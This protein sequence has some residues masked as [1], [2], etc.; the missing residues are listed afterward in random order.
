MSS[1][2]PQIA[3]FGLNGQL[4]QEFIKAFTSDRYKGH[5]QLPIRA[6]TR[7]P[8]KYA[9]TEDVE[10]VKADLNDAES[11]KAA[12]TGVNVVLDVTGHSVSSKP[13]IDAAVA[14]GVSLFFNS[15]FGSDISVPNMKWF[16]EAYALKLEEADYA[17]QH[18]QLKTVSVRNDVFADFVLPV[19]HGLFGVDSKTKTA[20]KYEGY[21]NK[22][23]V[24]WVS[25]IAKAVASIAYKDPKSLPDVVK[26]HG[27]SV[28]GKDVIEYFENKE[29]AKFELTTVSWEDTKKLA[30]E[31]DEKL[32]NKQ[33]SS[34]QEA[35]GLF[36]N[37]IR[38]YLLDPE[39][40]RVVDFADNNNNDLTDVEFRKW[41]E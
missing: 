24:T 9:S 15:E 41:Y 40:R 21:E 30:T 7:D 11:L 5:Y 34:P 25:D 13:L 10:Y 6:A 8:S 39:E 35:F 38:A 2:K 22:F 32:K 3:I 23:T 19:A 16:P 37:I 36:V 14:E 31:S 27:S 28:S 20:V 17:R 4:G 33:F 26:L 29:G 1:I 12:L 18:S